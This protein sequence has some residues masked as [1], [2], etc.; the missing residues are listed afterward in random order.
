MFGLLVIRWRWF[1][2]S[3]HLFV[4]QPGKPT[5]PRNLV[6]T[7]QRVSV[8]GN[9]NYRKS[10]NDAI[11]VFKKES[12]LATWSHAMGIDWMKKTRELAEAIPPAYTE[13]IGISIINQIKN[14]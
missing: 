12:V 6:T 13:Y 4:M 3:E 9:A 10:K 11:P 2:L 8:F 5:I 14:H 7:G 1:E